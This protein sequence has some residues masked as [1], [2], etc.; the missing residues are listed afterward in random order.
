MKLNVSAIAASDYAEAVYAN[1]LPTYLRSY[2]RFYLFVK[3]ITE[4][5]RDSVK[6]LQ[7]V[8]DIILNQGYVDVRTYS[9]NVLNMLATN[10]GVAGT[11]TQSSAEI[12]DAIQCIGVSRTAFATLDDIRKGFLDAARSISA[13][14]ILDNSIVSSEAART[15]MTCQ[16]TV[17][18]KTQLSQEFINSVI[19]IKVTGVFFTYST[20]YGRVFAYDYDEAD[21]SGSTVTYS[22]WEKGKWA[23]ET[24]IQH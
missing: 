10:Y 20:Q 13:Y 7:K 3:L 23:P 11:D 9:R 12:Y 2:K 19:V 8:N 18:P 22:G 17:Y 6:V 5:V 1:S 15:S 16:L 24:I 14:T 21:V 4:Y